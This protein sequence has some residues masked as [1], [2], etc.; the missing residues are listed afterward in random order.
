MGSLHLSSPH[1]KSVAFGPTT[2]GSNKELT[3]NL[4]EERRGDKE[5]AENNRCNAVVTSQAHVVHPEHSVLLT[6]V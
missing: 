4:V 6:T 1:K 3:D 5:Y 2:V